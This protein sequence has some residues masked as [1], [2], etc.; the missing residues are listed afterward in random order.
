MTVVSSFS[1][2]DFGPRAETKNRGPELLRLFLEYCAVQG[3]LS[4][5]GGRQETYELN[6]FERGVLDAMRSAGVPAVPQWG[7]S[8]YRIDFALAHPERPG[9]M[10]LAVETDGDRYHR[11][12][13]AR[14]RD[15]LRQAHLERL[16]WRFHRI[17][18]AD[19]F[20]DPQAETDRLVDVWQDVVRAADEP[21][22]G[23]VI[24]DPVPAPRRAEEP[25]NR[26]GPK[27]SL[28]LGG[29]I[30]TYSDMD[31]RTLAGWILSDGYQLD[32][33]TRISQAMTELGFRKRGRV[34]VE[35]LNQ[36][37]D[38]SQQFAD[39]EHI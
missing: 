38:H 24:Q 18:A 23:R 21:P 30:G 6:P 22:N 29:S 32:R 16:G 12:V 4:R 28:R 25:S 17:W 9:Q 15:R 2:H 20:A 27:P 19:W 10:L 8:G 36:A 13:S 5:S 11:T 35:R 37:F 31:L 26:R 39:K 1:H 34:I 7:V 3:D 33:D 14:D